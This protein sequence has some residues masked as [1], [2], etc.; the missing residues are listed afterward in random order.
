M[1]IVLPSK[2]A[3]NVALLK[4]MNSAANGLLIYYSRRPSEFYIDGGAL[5]EILLSVDFA[6]IIQCWR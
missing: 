3:Y 2:S 4:F 6:F 5:L 1:T